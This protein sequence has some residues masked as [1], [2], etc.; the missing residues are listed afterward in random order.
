MCGF[1]NFSKKCIQIAPIR[2]VISTSKAK[3]TV[4]RVEPMTSHIAV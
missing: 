2:S 3:A 1:R 4:V